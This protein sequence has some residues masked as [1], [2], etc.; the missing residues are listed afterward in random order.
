MS[1]SDNWATPWPFFARL[2]AEFDFTRDVA[3]SPEN[4]MCVDFWTEEDNALLQDWGG[5]QRLWC[6]PPYSKLAT[7]PWCE[8]AHHAS[9][10]GSTV[11]MLL[12]TTR[13]GTGY[14]WDWCRLAHEWR[15]VKGRIKFQDPYAHRNWYGSVQACQYRDRS[16][17]KIADC[18]CHHKENSSF[19]TFGNCPRRPPGRGN[20]RDHSVVVIW[21]PGPSGLLWPVNNG[22][23]AEV[24]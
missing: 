13:T 14:W 7:E 9:M 24:E 22:M 4:A 16:T 19:C 1:K 21:R 12:P 8:K 15:W 20:P 2:D 10:G 17:L 3:A 6:N 18:A 23:L 11:V 5:G